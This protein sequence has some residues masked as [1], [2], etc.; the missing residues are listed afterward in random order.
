[1]F[2]RLLA[3][4]KTAVIAAVVQVVVGLVAGLGMH[5][6]GIDVA[7]LTSL[8]SGG[9]GWVVHEHFNVKVKYTAEHTIR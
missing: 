4:D 5:L 2:Q 7:L 9:V 6:T 3:S 1:M 8:V